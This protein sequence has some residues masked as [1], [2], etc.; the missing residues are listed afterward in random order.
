L[1]FKRQDTFLLAAGFL[2]QLALE[3]SRCEDEAQ[4]LRLTTEAREM[5]LPDG[6]AA[7]FQVLVQRKTTAPVAANEE[8]DEQ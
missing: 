7:R 8:A 5:I 3:L 1:E 2:D 6:M 4:R